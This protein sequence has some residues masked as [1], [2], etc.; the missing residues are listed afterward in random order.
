MLVECSPAKTRQLLMARKKEGATVGVVPTMGA[1]HQGHL[2]L[3]DAAATDCDFVVA[4]IFV[5]PTQFGPNEDFKRYPRTLQSDLQLCEKAGADLV[6]T[7]DT[8]DMYSSDAATS[9]HVS[10]LTEVLEGAL[11]PGHFDG[12][13]TV[14]AKLFNITVPDK[15][16]FGQKDYQQQLIVRRMIA[17]LNWGI[18]IVTCP[19]V[20][21][22]DGLAMSSR[23]RYLSADQRQQALVLSRSLELAEMLA[24]EC[25]NL[26]NDIAAKMQQLV[27][28][29][30]GVQLDYAV[31]VDCE[32]LQ[33]LSHRPSQA[34]ALIAA[35][36]G[37]T[38]LIDNAILRF[39]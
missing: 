24:A 35:K 26:P 37:T 6:F 13:T 8:A 19:T 21:E 9:V 33:T 14:V 29:S 23:N 4:T 36:L 17:D 7:P 11:R 20:R 30:H 5:N 18:E 32:T 27:Q 3:I 34:V 15:A 31:V 2:N 1:L 12:V 39:T 22:S 38:R 16:F 28:E 10:R 25:G